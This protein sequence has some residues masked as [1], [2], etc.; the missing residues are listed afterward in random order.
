MGRDNSTFSLLR[1]LV[2]IPTVNPPG[3]GYRDLQL[4]VMRALKR[5]GARVRLFELEPG[6]PNLVASVGSGRPELL[7]ST[8]IDV[9]D[10]GPGWVSN[11]FKV[12]ETGGKIYG[13]GTADAKGPL[14]AM[15]SAFL[16]HARKPKRLHGT[17]T[18]ASTVDEETGGLAGMG[19]LVRNRVLNPDFTVI[20]EPTGLDI[21]FCQKG[22][23]WCEITF[24]GKPAHAATPN[25]GIDAIEGMTRLMSRLKS[26][27]FAGRHP[28]LG[29]PSINIGLISGGTAANTVPSKCTITLDRRI[30]PN[31][32]TRQIRKYLKK[33]VLRIVRSG[34]AVDYSMR[35]ILVAEPVDQLPK[36]NFIQRVLS[37]TTRVKKKAKLTGIFG[38]TDARYLYHKNRRPVVVIGPGRISQAHTANEYVS[39]REMEMAVEAYDGIIQRTLV[40]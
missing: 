39:K 20:G 34:Q 23:Y 27:K 5:E 8:H 4:L 15:L 6:K 3:R 38:F 7:L 16:T 24:I 18:F 14:A 11:P 22:V 36:N 37:A 10:V 12:R 2:S 31:E 21:A 25:L 9:V 26:P 13:R 29:T 33:E 19:A 1:R 17:L 30:L 32:S 35:D 28:F 40:D